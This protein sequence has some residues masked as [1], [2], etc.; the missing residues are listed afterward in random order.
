MERNFSC[1]NKSLAAALFSCAVIGG[2]AAHAAD[3]QSYTINLTATVPSDS[4]HVIPVDA[5]WIDQTQDMGYDIA[6]SKLKVFE[7]QFQY[8]N[9]AGGIQ[10]TLTGN[11]SS[12]GNPQLSNGTDVIPLAVSFNNVA[13]SKTATTVV[14]AAAAKAGGRTA[15]RIAQA[16]DKALDVNG[17]FTGSVSMIFEPAV[18]TPEA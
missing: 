5:G 14:E 1:L 18:V 8:K 12:D 10:A 13:L 6:T 4:F 7:K 15:L 17:S 2:V 16:D 3:S 11:L 9:T